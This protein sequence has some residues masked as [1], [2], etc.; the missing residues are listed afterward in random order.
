MATQSAETHEQAIQRLH[1]EACE[2]GRKVYR[3]PQT[4]VRV[5]TAAF[6]LSRG[7]CCN[8]ECRHCPFPPQAIDSRGTNQLSGRPDGIAAASK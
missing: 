6:L 8:L 3:D 1:S 2:K 5:C 4:R 7:F